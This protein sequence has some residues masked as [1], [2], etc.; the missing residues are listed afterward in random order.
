MGFVMGS[1]DLGI[2]ICLHRRDGDW[3]GPVSKRVASGI[4]LTL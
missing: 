3:V 1:T 2:V 4:Y